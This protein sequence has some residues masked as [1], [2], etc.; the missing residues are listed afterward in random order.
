MKITDQI[1]GTVYQ[2]YFE[3]ASTCLSNLPDVFYSG[4]SYTV[5][6]PRINVNLVEGLLFPTRL[7][8]I[9]SVIG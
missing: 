5:F 9:Q 1:M 2:I 6:T 7:N 4:G 3:V 8:A